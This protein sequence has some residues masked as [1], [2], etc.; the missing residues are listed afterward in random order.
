[1][2][3]CSE[4]ACQEA[5]GRAILRSISSVEESLAPSDKIGKPMSACTM[6]G[7]MLD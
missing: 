7:S 2:L 5:E 3:R 4:P 1:M 6:E